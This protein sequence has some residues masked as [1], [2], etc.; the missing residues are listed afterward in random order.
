[1]KPS[2]ESIMNWT[3]MVKIFFLLSIYDKFAYTMWQWMFQWMFEYNY[4]C[5]ELMISGSG[6]YRKFSDFSGQSDKFAY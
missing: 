3:E 4:F 1:M 6:L 5:N 2:W